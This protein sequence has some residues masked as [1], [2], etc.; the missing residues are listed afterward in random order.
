[1]LRDGNRR[2][3]V[4]DSRILASYNIHAFAEDPSVFVLI[5]RLVAA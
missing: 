2:I 4:L 1:M 5:G 3:G